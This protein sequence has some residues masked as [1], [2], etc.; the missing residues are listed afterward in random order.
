MCGPY[1]EIQIETA[2]VSDTTLEYVIK[3]YINVNDE[4]IASDTEIS[5]LTRNVIDD[6][7]RAIMVNQQMDGLAENITIIDHGTAFE[8]VNDNIEFF[9]YV[10]LEIQT[11]INSNNPYL[12]G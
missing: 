11:L 4:K 7:V 3:Y 9:V 1:A 12:L 2:G 8:L 10:D 6:I 5:Y